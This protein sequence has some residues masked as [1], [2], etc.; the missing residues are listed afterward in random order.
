MSI[1][2]SDVANF[3]SLTG[4]GM[5]DCKNALEEAA[6]D[7]DKAADI[8]R[9]KG[10]IKAAKRA[11]KIASEGT[12]NVE[13]DGN[14]AV[15]AEINSETDFVAKNDDFKQMVE[16]LTN[17]LL[18]NK[19]DSVEQSLGQVM[20][21]ESG[22]VQDYLTSTTAK[23]GE[24][25]SLR[26]FVVLEKSDNDVFGTYIHM[27]GK[28]GVAVILQGSRDQ[29]LAKDIAM[30]AAA[31]APKYLVREAV[32]AEVIDQE[33]EVYTAQLKNEGKPENIIANILNGKLNKFYSE[34]CLVDQLFIKDDK[35]K[36]SELLPAGVK[37][38]EF[39]R[40]EL[41]EGIDNKTGDFAAEVQK[42]MG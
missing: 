5:M 19:S 6:G 28:I 38:K 3:R 29:T 10:V 12:I 13:V 9:K 34:V 24:K 15:V 40:Y 8:L 2:A 42:Q 41:G 14:A 26:R 11:G 39:V 16:K 31:A 21:G 7:V 20:A 4:A 22:T 17:H 37:I 18:A 35:K 27:G 32:P 23:I 25:I 36:V 33:K 1:S 30:H